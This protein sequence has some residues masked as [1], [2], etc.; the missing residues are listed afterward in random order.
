MRRWAQPRQP[1]PA[2]PPRRARTL[3]SQ[4]PA[5]ASWAR[6]SADSRDRWRPAPP[7]TPLS[8]DDWLGARRSSSPSQNGGL[9]H[10]APA[11]ERRT[12]NR[13]AEPA[14][15]PRGGRRRRAMDARH[16]TPGTSRSKESSRLP[17]WRSS[18]RTHHPARLL[19]PAAPPVRCVRS[20]HRT[21]RPR[22]D[23]SGVRTSR[24][25]PP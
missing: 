25:R 8:A 22:V 6:A 11:N 20:Q 2:R 12:P 17:S 5:A 4:Q 18:A 1:Q 15:R 19:R 9:W 14:Y 16:G 23:Q 21:P 3:T 24:Q 13:R 7:P 10:H